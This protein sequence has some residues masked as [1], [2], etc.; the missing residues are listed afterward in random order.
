MTAGTRP[1]ADDIRAARAADP[2]SRERDFAAGLGISEAEYVA[3]WCDGAAGDTRGSGADGIRARRIKPFGREVLGEMP[4]LGEVMSLT[5]NDSAVHETI[6]SY[7]RFMSN[8]G[9]AAAIGD[10]INLRLFFK[11]WAHGF[12]VERQDGET[13]RRSLQ[14]FDPA[15][16]AVQKIH[17]RP[18]SRLDAYEALVTRLLSEDQ[19]RTLA[20]M[21]YPPAP[22]DAV[23]VAGFTRRD[24]LRSRWAALEDVHQFYPMLQEIG[25]SRHV[26]V[27]AVGEEHAW[28][29][30]TGSVAAALERV[31]TSGMPA[32]CFVGSR[33][34][35]QIYG[36][37]ITQLKAMGPWLNVMDPS[38]HLHLRTDHIAEVWAL[39]R[40]ITEGW[41]SSLDAYDAEGRLILQ[42]F[43][44]REMGHDEPAD[45]R[46]LVD[47]LPRL[48]Y[49]LAA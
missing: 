15:G 36:G 22:E 8:G 33:G 19:S 9:A 4:K 42:L 24:D 17:L 28:P 48:P 2:R 11:H 27:Q 12:A 43:G 46:A 34:C 30:E 14:F 3:A 41:L 26:A 16:D 5:R 49:P 21:P 47:A 37:R 18:A 32:M 39:R 6:G 7:G 40:P 44:A 45:W 29:V 1:T 23:T 13:T 20:T 31:A 10:N 35:V 25:V 38:F